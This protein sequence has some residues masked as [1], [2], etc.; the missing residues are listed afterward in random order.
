[1]KKD[2]PILEMMNISM[3][4]PGVKA[5]DKVSLKAYPGEV[6]ALVG[7]NG[8]GK[9]TLMKVLSGVW[10]YP[11]Y[12][13]K[14]KVKNKICRFRHTHD[15]EEIGIAIIY[16]ELNLIYDLSVAEN[17]YLDRQP[18]GPLGLIDW[19]QMYAN[20][21]VLLKQLHIHNIQPDDMV[22]ELSVG[23]QQM[24][25]IAKALSQ[26]AEILILDEPTSALS[27]RECDELFRI[28]ERLKKEK[29]AM[30]YIS[31]KMEEIKRIADKVQV[32]RDGQSID[33]TYPIDK[34]TLN[35]IITR[36]VGR[37]ISTMYPSHKTKKGETVLE[38]R[39]ISLD[40]PVLPGRKLVDNVSFEA[41]QGEILGISGLMGSG[42]TELVMSIFGAAAGRVQGEVY[43]DGRKLNI[44]QPHDAIKAGLALVTEDRKLQGLILEQ[45]IIFNTTLASLESITRAGILDHYQERAI[46]EKY[47]KELGTKTASLEH[48]VNTLSGGNQQKV[49]IAKWL[50]TSPRVLILDDPTRGIDI[51]AK[52][53]I[54]KL[55]NKLVEQGVC[56]IMI[57]SELPE[58]LGMCDRILVMN[59]GRKVADLDRKNADEE[60]IMS[61]ATGNN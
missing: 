28:I 27:D 35:D 11:E 49:V 31:H 57:S 45:D 29:V 3:S 12:S 43:L 53:E 55:M 42:R 58:I 46:S 32:L 44:R 6:L 24:V 61:L 4:F 34:I 38:V 50:A 19:H 37:D 13:G 47:N 25:E 7:E 52:V 1:M 22:R 15:A 16:Q 21:A 59:E 54:Y 26:N 33:D 40:H 36:M 9:S 56:V 10:P 18:R 30:I 23:Q 8:A 5:L 48:A 60:K 17:I 14:L 20:A 51:G 2:S 39:G 41:C